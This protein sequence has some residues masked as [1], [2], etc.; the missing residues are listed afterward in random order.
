MPCNHENNN[1]ITTA[2]RKVNENEK[3]FRYEKGFRVSL[4]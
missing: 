3:A 2:A 1:Y 4:N